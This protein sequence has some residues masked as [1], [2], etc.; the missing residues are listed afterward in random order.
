MTRAKTTKRDPKTA[1]YYDASKVKRAALA[2]RVL[3]S[4][5]KQGIDA[6][7]VRGAFE[8]TI[9]INEP[10]RGNSFIQYDICIS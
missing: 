2:K 9:C 3:A 5:K 1:A 8:P 10:S 6:H 4:L 7:M